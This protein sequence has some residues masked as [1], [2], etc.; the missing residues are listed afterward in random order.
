MLNAEC[1]WIEF[2]KKY[3]D[4]SHMSNL[5]TSG[6]LCICKLQHDQTFFLVSERFEKKIQRSF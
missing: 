6:F 3:F 5:T 4:Q 2:D 1:N